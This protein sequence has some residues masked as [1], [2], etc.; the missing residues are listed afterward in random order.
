MIAF[1]LWNTQLD[2][3]HPEYNQLGYIDHLPPL[4]HSGTHLYPLC[5]A[6]IL[7]GG[8]YTLGYSVR[9]GGQYIQGE[10]GG[11]TMYPRVYCPGRH[12]IQGD[13]ISSDTG[14]G[15]WIV[16]PCGLSLRTLC[17]SV[18]CPLGH[19]ALGQTVPP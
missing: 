12:F 17:T 13:I 15:G 9:G 7:W 16:P 19:S 4:S 1:G 11:G 8:Q 10:G 6:T 2:N 14:V 3:Y 18:Q 5:C